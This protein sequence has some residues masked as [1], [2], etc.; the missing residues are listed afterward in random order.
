M[1]IIS[2]LT[3]F[4]KENKTKSFRDFLF[5]FS[6]IFL[7]VLFN[8]PFEN[9][10]NEYLIKYVFSLVQKGLAVDILSLLAVIFYILFNA[11]KFKRKYQI[12][13]GSLLLEL[14]FALAYFHYRYSEKEWTFLRMELIPFIAYLDLCMIV[15]FLDVILFVQNVF[16]FPIEGVSELNSFKID[17]PISEEKEDELNRSSYL[18]HL[19]KK[20]KTTFNDKSSFAIGIIGTWGS[21]KSSF[22]QVLE[23]ELSKKN[24]FDIN[25]YNEDLIKYL[26]SRENIIIKFIPWNSNSSEN[27]VKDFFEIFGD[28]LSKYNNPIK[29]KLSNYSDNLVKINEN[30]ITKTI[31]GT[32]DTF[33]SEPLKAQQDDI[34]D[35]IKKINKQIIVFIDDLDRL[36]KKEIIEVLRLIRNTANFANTVFIVAYDRAV[37]VSAIKELTS[38]NHEFYLEKIFQLEIPLPKH[39]AYILREILIKQ[40]A[41]IKNKEDYEKIKSFINQ[42]G[43]INQNFQNED[44]LIKD[45]LFGFYLQNIR[46]INRF[47]NSLLLSYEILKDRVEILDLFLI[48]LLKTKFPLVYEYVYFNRAEILIA[49]K[50]RGN[51]ESYFYCLRREEQKNAIPKTEGTIIVTPIFEKNKDELKIHDKHIPQIIN[52]LTLLFSISDFGNKRNISI[53]IQKISCFNFYFTFALSEGEFSE[54]EFSDYRQNKTIVEFIDKIKGWVQKGFYAN[55][56]RRFGETEDFESKEDFEKVMFAHF[57]FANSYYTESPKGINYV[58]SIEDLYEKLSDESNRVT[59]WYY[60]KDKNKYKNFL[61]KLFTEYSGNGT[62]ELMFITELINKDIVHLPFE[63][64][65]LTAYANSIF[66]KVLEVKTKFGLSVWS[67]LH[68]MRI[69]QNE[70]GLDLLESSI[71]EAVIDFAINKDIKGFLSAFIEQQPF[72]R[73]YRL[74]K[75]VLVFF[76]SLESFYRFL[77]P[78]KDNADVQEM[79]FFYG[80]VSFHEFKRYV[81]FD[82]EYL[83]PELREP[84][85][86]RTDEERTEF[87]V[88]FYNVELADRVFKYIEKDSKNKV[89]QLRGV[90]PQKLFYIINE[91]IGKEKARNKISKIIID[92]IEK[93]PQSLKFL[94]FETFSSGGLNVDGTIDINNKKIA[95]IVSTFELR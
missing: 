94:S 67:M 34:S 57:A 50:K 31:K 60:N 69:R 62:I 40:L 1:N 23:K 56:L 17:L 46:D 66:L 64:S 35:C 28:E 10:I 39:R 73:R 22:L 93:E 61:R 77:L 24:V 52:I 43:R 6:I 38:E 3:D 85:K 79:L 87:L 4:Y 91:V 12:S 2:K 78:L 16:S 51:S 5:P 58:V 80:L 70:E 33:Y 65:E 19:A 9:F 21:G 86:L 83:E 76:D 82:F 92:A 74:N 44:W 47:T 42:A 63:K 11:S 13:F 89:K 72:F 29:K 68:M 32:I 30:V 49:S 55:L 45:E 90:E 54:F 71:R 75:F 88:E 7:V 27:I 48:E 95:K 20:I 26:N 41:F 15:I 25:D 18:K 8:R 59:D 84:R 36:D 14:F 81:A 37:V 53:S